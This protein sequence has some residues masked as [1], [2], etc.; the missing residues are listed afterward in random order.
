MGHAGAGGK[1][2]RQLTDGVE[3]LR[4]WPD[5]LRGVIM[6]SGI[7]CLA[8]GSLSILWATSLSAEAPASVAGCAQVGAV[9][10]A[11]ELM[12]IVP[13]HMHVSTPDDGTRFHELFSVL[14]TPSSIGVRYHGKDPAPFSTTGG[15]RIGEDGLCTSDSRQ[16]PWAC[17]RIARCASGEAE[18]VGWREGDDTGWAY[19]RIA[20]DAAMRIESFSDDMATP[21]APT[22]SARPVY[23]TAHVAPRA[24]WSVAEGDVFRGF[25]GL[26]GIYIA[27][28][29]DDGPLI[30]DYVMAQDYS[31]GQRIDDGRRTVSTL[32]R[33][34]GE[35]LSVPPLFHWAT[36]G[37]TNE[38]MFGPAALD[39]D[40]LDLATA[41]PG[42]IDIV[43]SAEGVAGWEHWTMLRVELFSTYVRWDPATHASDGQV[44]VISP[45]GDLL[46]RSVLVCE[47]A[48]YAGHAPQ[49]TLM[50]G[51][52]ICRR[53]DRA[54]EVTEVLRG[55]NALQVAAAIG[56]QEHPLVMQVGEIAVTGDTITIGAAPVQPFVLINTG[57]FQGW[58]DWIDRAQA[59][60]G[61]E[62]PVTCRFPLSDA[63]RLGDVEA[64]DLLRFYAGLA[65]ASDAGVQL[66]CR[67]D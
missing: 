59:T 5:I 10:S 49:V 44:R 48:E 51:E 29:A 13:G 36:D 64:G 2:K 50:G 4:L 3:S 25:P 15:Y 65:G 53:Y 16:G 54:F 30:R 57:Q 27:E 66:D 62:R 1:G 23:D 14:V 60:G 28:G 52:P 37:L 67:L 42:V 32:L 22:V 33:I 26:V 20:A 17:Q 24:D 8:G 18:Y 47:A 56:A 40:R 63:D 19:S 61:R 12:E 7:R 21:A 34:E 31:T 46:S 39:G 58:A 6:R 45:M 35:G 38:L 41:T 11:A 9:L 55:K 43:T